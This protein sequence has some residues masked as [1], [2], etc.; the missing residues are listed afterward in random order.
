MAKKLSV[1]LIVK[2][3]EEVLD[4]CLECVSKFADEIVVVDTGSTDRTKEIAKKWTPNVFDFEWQND[5]SLARNYSISKATG[6]YV[7][8]IDADDYISTSNIKKIVKLKENLCFDTYMLKY[9]VAFDENGKPTFEYFRERIIKNCENCKFE[10]FI[11]EAIVPFGKISYENIAIEHRKNKKSFDKKRNL[12]IYNFHIQNGDVLNARETFYYARELF[13]NG[14]YK[15][16]IKVL[17]KFLKMEN[18]F[19][20]NVN[21]SYIIISDC[22]LILKQYEK[23]KIYLIESIKI[24]DPNAEICCKIGNLEILKN[25]YN[26]AI[27]WYKMA[28][29]SQKNEKSGAFV[30]ND[31]YDFI[32]YLQLSFCHYYIGDYKNFVKYHKKAKKLKPY[33]KSVL[34]NEKFI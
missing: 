24:A 8:W 26:S 22:F 28:L 17:K 18:L 9:Q 21:D 31:Y 14:F 2:N 25:D 15:K 11:H 19:L 23:A 12:K 33:D 10:G 7:V 32:P 6:E 3:E 5:F 29:N 27:F 34:N 1:C 4:R 13:Y 20:P 30:E 16:T